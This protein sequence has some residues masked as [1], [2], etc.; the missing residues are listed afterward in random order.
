MTA[1]DVRAKAWLALSSGT[2]FKAFAAFF[3]LWMV[4]QT[5]NGLLLKVGLATG[6]MAI[7]TVADLA[8]ALNAGLTPP[9]E[10]AAIKIPNPTLLY[11]MVQFLAE[12]ALPGGVLAAGWAVFA[13]ALVRGGAQVMHV[14][15]GFSRFFR[16]AALGVLLYGAVALGTLLL[17]VPGVMLFYSFR[18]SFFLLA[19][20][21]DW[22][23]VKA[24]GA[25]ARMMA[26]HRWRLACLDVSFLGWTLLEAVTLGLASVLVRPYREVAAAVFYEDLLDREEDV[27]V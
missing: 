15:S 14:F 19:D 1:R 5:L 4:G 26:G 7:V 2:W 20:H 25:S 18:M 27:S 3:L 21:P 23:P 8:R 24:L 22:S 11:R 9:P 10:W 12:A 13:V 17:V 6:Q 16:T